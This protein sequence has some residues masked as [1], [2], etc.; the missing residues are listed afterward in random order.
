MATGRSLSVPPGPPWLLAEPEVRR[1]AVN[2]VELMH[3]DT[4]SANG[5]A[6]WVAEFR[7][8]SA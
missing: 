1:V 2:G 4:V 8:P 3:L 7:R 5:G 6:R